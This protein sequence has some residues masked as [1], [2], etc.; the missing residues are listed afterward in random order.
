MNISWLDSRD[1]CSP[2]LS[3]WCIDLFN[4]LCVICWLAEVWLCPIIQTINARDP[5][6]WLSPW[7]CVM[8]HGHA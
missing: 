3:L 7:H 2:F 1:S 6:L 5:G 8:V 4:L